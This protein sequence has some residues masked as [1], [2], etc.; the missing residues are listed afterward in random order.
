MRGAHNEPFSLD[1]LDDLVRRW[2]LETGVVNTGC[3]R[4]EPVKP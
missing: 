1:E 3:G 4:T 2:Q